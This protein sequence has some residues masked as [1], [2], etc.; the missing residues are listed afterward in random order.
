MAMKTNGDISGATGTFSGAVTASNIASFTGTHYTISKVDA[1]CVGDIAICVEDAFTLDVSQS[2]P[3]TDKSLV[4]S[5]KR[6][7]GVFTGTVES[8]ESIGVKYKQMTEHIDGGTDDNGDIVMGEDVLIE[9]YI[10]IVSDLTDDGNQCAFVN[11]IGEGMINVCEVG[12]DIENGDFIT[13]S[14]VPG[15]GMK[16][17]D[18]LLHNYTVAKALESTVWADEVDG[19]NGVYMTTGSDGIEYKTKMVACSYHAG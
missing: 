13:S 10:T 7:L 1:S 12:G 16:Q 3:I 11:S 14:I 18:D 19:T 2:F 8:L 6:V 4:P 15:K 5:D 9:P 17:S